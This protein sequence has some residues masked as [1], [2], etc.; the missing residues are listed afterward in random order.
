M[1][2]LPLVLGTIL[3]PLDSPSGIGEGQ[4]AV[5][6][7]TYGTVPITKQQLASATGR[8]ENRPG[9]QVLSG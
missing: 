5:R 6:K 9:T 2:L 8:V 1:Q 3:I 4:L 7:I